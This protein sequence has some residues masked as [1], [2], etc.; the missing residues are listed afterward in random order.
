MN[1]LLFVCTGNYYRSRFA[2]VLFNHLA[3]RDGLPWR[4]D[5]R[6]LRLWPGN[7]GP[8]SVHALG[9]LRRLK[10]EHDADRRF[11]V[12]MTEDDLRA[13]HLIVALKQTEHRPMFEHSFPAWADR[14]EYWHIDDVD[15]REPA[16][17]LVELEHAVAALAGR[18]QR[19]G[20][21]AVD[22]SERQA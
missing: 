7:E 12:L 5:S 20:P 11:P 19:T 16:L 4:A 2:E 22:Q 18:L 13:A 8:I 10:I 14:V 9:G 3:L 21:V 17:A 6:A 1:T 15:C